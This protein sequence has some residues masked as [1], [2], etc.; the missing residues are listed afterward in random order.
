MDHFILFSFS[1]FDNQ[2]F[3]C[4]YGRVINHVAGM[5][6]STSPHMAGC[7]LPFCMS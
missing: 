5:L 4:D 2:G 7:T 3:M 6:E 1:L